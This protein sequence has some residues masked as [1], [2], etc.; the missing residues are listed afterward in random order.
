MTLSTLPYIT[1]LS[2]VPGALIQSIGT[3]ACYRESAE[4]LLSQ[5]WTLD[6][7]LCQAI[8][9]VPTAAGADYFLDL[10]LLDWHRSREIFMAIRAHKDEIDASHPHLGHVVSLVDYVSHM[11]TNL[12]PMSPQKRRLL[13]SVSAAGNALEYCGAGGSSF[14]WSMAIYFGLSPFPVFGVNVSYE[15]EAVVKSLGRFGLGAAPYLTIALRPELAYGYSVPAE[16]ARDGV[17]RPVVRMPLELLLD[18]SFVL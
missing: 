16:I 12:L 9:A 18:G 4:R 2:S 8:D 5:V 14:E 10:S 7:H 17:D 3:S 1:P 15:D 11:T 6:T 13:A